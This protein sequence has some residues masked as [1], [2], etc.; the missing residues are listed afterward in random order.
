[1]VCSGGSGWVREGGFGDG[2][3]GEV[4]GD[5]VDHVALAAVAAGAGL[6]GLHEGVDPFQQAVVQSAGV[7]GDDAVPVPLHD[8]YEVLDRLQP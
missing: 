2:G 7:S 6:G 5:E 4:A 8:R 1:V 3:Q